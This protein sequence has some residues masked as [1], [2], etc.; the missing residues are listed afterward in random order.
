MAR[1]AGCGVCTSTKRTGLFYGAHVCSSCKIFFMRTVTSHAVY[2][3]Q[4]KGNCQLGV[5]SD[6]DL[7]QE[8]TQKPQLAICSADNFDRDSLY[9]SHAVGYS[10]VQLLKDTRD[11]VIAFAEKLH[12]LEVYC[13]YDIGE[14]NFDMS[15]NLDVTLEAA[16]TNP[17]MLCKRTPM[18]WLGK[19]DPREYGLKGIQSLFARSG[20]AYIDWLTAS[21]ELHMMSDSDKRRL[22]TAQFSEIAKITTL[23]AIYKLQCDGYLFANGCTCRETDHVDP[24]LK[25]LV[26]HAQTLIRPLLE[27]LKIRSQ[28][29]CILKQ[30][31]FYSCNASLSDDGQ[32]ICRRARQKY[33]QVLIAYVAEA[34]PDLTESE[35]T[36]RILDLYEFRL[37][38]RQMSIT[39]QVYT[40]SLVLSDKN[41]LGRMFPR[42][43]TFG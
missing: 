16:L 28:E 9:T 36:R 17:T 39:T 10:F 5:G 13:Q 43:L 4:E 37:Y 27:R 29:Y 15:C 2:S 41:G 1:Q 33:E 7:E 38:V 3:C 11:G 32:K 26:R 24:Y 8:E 12:A 30:I 25:K 18:Y 14:S 6:S 23:Y 40:E 20:L 21:P 31:I 35:R 22:I 42:D 19:R 34:Y